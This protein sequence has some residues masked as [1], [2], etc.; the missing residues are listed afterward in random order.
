M[1]HQGLVV[2]PLNETPSETRGRIRPAPGP[3]HVKLTYHFR[4]RISL[5]KK[6]SI[7][8]SIL[9]DLNLVELRTA[10]L[11]HLETGLWLTF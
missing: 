11:R 8:L 2:S 7:I 6:L 1:N 3:L 10:T 9:V 5:D 4:E